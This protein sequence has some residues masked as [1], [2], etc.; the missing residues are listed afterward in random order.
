MAVPFGGQRIGVVSVMGTD[1]QPLCPDGEPSLA[2]LDP[3]DAARAAASAVRPECDLVV[4]MAYADQETLDR[5][6]Q[7]P[8]VD[9]VIASRTMRRPPGY[10][11]VGMRGHAALGYTGY[12]ARR[13]GT[14]EITRGPDGRVESVTGDLVSLGESIPDDPAIAA[15]IEEYGSLD[16]HDVK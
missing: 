7:I 2:L 3:V 4:V 15:I 5:L 11:N 8:E 6:L 1:V 10:D 14:M 16:T 13:I 12:Q 9:V